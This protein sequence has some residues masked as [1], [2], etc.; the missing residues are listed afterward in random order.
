MHPVLAQSLPLIAGAAYAASALWSK[1]ATMEGGGL[2]RII[3]LTNWGQALLLLPLAFLG[4]GSAL[5]GEAVLKVAIT[6]LI[7]FIG[8]VVV[9]AGLRFGDVSVLTPVMGTKVLVVALMA[10]GFM[11]ETLPPRWWLAAAIAT[12]AAALLGG[13]AVGDRRRV[14]AGVAGGLG[15]ALAFAGVDICFQLWGGTVGVWRFTSLVMLGMGGW[16]LLLLPFLEGPWWR[17]PVPARSAF[18]P[19]LAMALTQTTLMAYCVVVLNGA[20]W[21]NLLYSSRGVWSVVFVWALGSW[22]GNRESE[23]GPGVMTQ[24]LLGSGLLLGA[25]AIVLY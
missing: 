23:I 11:H 3:F 5:G 12:L 8:Q 9:F 21:A 2:W 17:L 25:I 24:R 4:N 20:A 1:R 15:G 18:I 6:S 10:V 22:F 7:F 19:S 16:S 13:G 14:W